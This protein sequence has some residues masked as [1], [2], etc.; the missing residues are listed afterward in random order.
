MRI[1][2]SSE[3][4]GDI[5]EK[6]SMIHQW[7]FPKHSLS[8]LHMSIR[9]AF[10]AASAA[11]APEADL[12]ELKRVPPPPPGAPPTSRRTVDRPGFWGQSRHH[13]SVCLLMANVSTR[14]PGHR[15]QMLV[16]SHPASQDAVLIKTKVWM[17]FFL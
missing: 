9:K 6:K 3:T 10:S 7:N 13:V 8:I 5:P 17:H 4:L 2:K 12:G 16:P 11:F 14:S 1:M 15:Q